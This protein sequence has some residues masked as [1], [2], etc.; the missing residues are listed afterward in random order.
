LDSFKRT[1]TKSAEAGGRGKS[2]QKRSDGSKNAE[3]LGLRREAYNV[4]LSLISGSDLV[5]STPREVEG[6]GSGAGRAEAEER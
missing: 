1:T 3:R 2:G 6:V 4:D 5:E